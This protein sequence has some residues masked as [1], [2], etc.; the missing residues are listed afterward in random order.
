M[1]DVIASAG[2]VI[3][4]I[5]RTVMGLSDRTPLIDRLGDT[6]EQVLRRA[7]A[8]GRSSTAVAGELALE[9][10]AAGR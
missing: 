7:H 5:G 6:A 3:E 8:E 4:G 1:P 9:R 10:I 2:A